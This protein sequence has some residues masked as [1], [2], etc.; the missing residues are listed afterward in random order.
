[1]VIVAEPAA[2]AAETSRSA[3][4]EIAMNVFLI[5]MS[6]LLRLKLSVGRCATSGHPGANPTSLRVFRSR[7]TTRCGCGRR[8]RRRSFEHESWEL[9][10][11]VAGRREPEARREAAGRLPA[12]ASLEQRLGP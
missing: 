6:R 4:S 9:C 2:D 3:V 10:G 5:D 8:V 1:M 11:L 12:P 7:A